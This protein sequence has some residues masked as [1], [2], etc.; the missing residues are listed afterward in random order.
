[1]ASVQTSGNV[2]LW[3]HHVWFVLT[4]AWKMSTWKK[5]AKFSTHGQLQINSKCSLNNPIR[6]S[7]L[8]CLRKLSLIQLLFIC[9]CRRFA[10]PYFVVVRVNGLVRGLWT[11][12]SPTTF[13]YSDKLQDPELD[14]CET[15][16]GTVGYCSHC[17]VQLRK[18]E[19]RRCV[20]WCLSFTSVGRKVH[21]RER[22]QLS[23]TDV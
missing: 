2:L 14:K 8:L 7:N 5:K 19:Q 22:K 23:L 12:W 15:L 11:S 21:D 17:Q 3:V 4:R 13:N 16:C 1:M 20:C 9:H 6:E 10:P 18:R